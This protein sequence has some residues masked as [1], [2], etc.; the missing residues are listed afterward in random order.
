MRLF[1]STKAVHP[2]QTELEM[3]IVPGHTHCFLT[4]TETFLTA[5]LVITLLSYFR[6]TRSQ[7]QKKTQQVK[8]D[9]FNAD[10]LIIQVEFFLCEMEKLSYLWSWLHQKGHWSK[11][12]A[13][14]GCDKCCFGEAVS[15]WRKIKGSMRLLDITLICKESEILFP[16]SL[17]IILDSCQKLSPLCLSSKLSM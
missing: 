5:Q 3:Q 11:D 10:S 7:R 15:P 4:A 2:Q 17:N 14:N 9:Q 12:N 1:L 8:W 13:G 16:I 6:L